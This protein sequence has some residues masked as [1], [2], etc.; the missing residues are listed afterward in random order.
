[1]D[2]AATDGVST[3]GSDIGWV[4]L[5][6]VAGTGMRDLIDAA[7]SVAD[8]GWPWPTFLVNIVGAFLL[9]VV[10]AGLLRIATLELRRRVRLIVGTGFC[11][12]FT[13]YSAIALQLNTMADGGA[14]PVAIT[15]AA[16]SLVVGVGAAWMGLRLVSIADSGGRR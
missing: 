15:Y 8:R 13:T 14:L 7:I 11:G 2:D 5:G 6:G 1:M 16:A 3:A 4:F 10:T 9:G 12:A